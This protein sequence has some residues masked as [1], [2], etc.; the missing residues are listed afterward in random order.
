M[1]RRGMGAHVGVKQGKLAKHLSRVS[2]SQ[3]GGAPAYT[4]LDHGGFSSRFYAVKPSARNLLTNDV[5]RKIG[6]KF[7]MTA[8]TGSSNNFLSV[9]DR[10]AISL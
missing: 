6:G 4:A 3:T 5:R 2:D 7:N 9:E 1:E 8:E 10:D